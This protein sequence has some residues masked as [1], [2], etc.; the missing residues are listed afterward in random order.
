[1]KTHCSPEFLLDVALAGAPAVAGITARHLDGCESCMKRL[2]RLR[3]EVAAV[4][5]TAVASVISGSDCLD[6][7]DI[8]MLVDGAVGKR[9][10]AQHAHVAACVR[11]R[12][13]LGA[14]ARTLHSDAVALQVLRLEGQ[15]AGTASRVRWRGVPTR[16]VMAA[17]AA[18]LLAV[19][20]LPLMKT[21]LTR[22]TP[23]TR[24]PVHRESAITLTAAPKIVAP[25]GLANETQP[26]VWTS[27]PHADR[28]Q[29]KVFDGDGTLVVDEQTS[30]TTV[31][32]PRRLARAAPTTYYWK[33]EA[34][35]GWDRWVASEWRE[36]TVG[37]GNGR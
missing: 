5:R 24:D 7:N 21:A 35:T 9:T 10:E 19:A 1:V 31:A 12:V 15:A 30:D 33:V 3:E 6:D 17:L 36:L 4:R 26:L 2:I 8:A 27:V 28:Y 11:C 16:Q 13:R 23:E 22:S 20:S 37:P 14:V 29:L 18:A 25:I 34:R 32:M